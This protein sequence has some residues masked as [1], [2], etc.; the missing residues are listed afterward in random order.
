MSLRDNPLHGAERLTMCFLSVAQLQQNSAPHSLFP[1]KRRYA[2]MWGAG[3]KCDFACAQDYSKSNPACG[4]IDCKRGFLFYITLQK[5]SL[6]YAFCAPVCRSR[7]F[8]GK[9]SR[10]GLNCCQNSGGEENRTQ[11]RRRTLGFPETHDVSFR[12]FEKKRVNPFTLFP[13][14]A[15]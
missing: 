4:V 11:S 5:A 9:V 15:A 7:G 8:R 10:H 2:Q 3:A 1:Y 14:T 13:A 6:R 12:Q